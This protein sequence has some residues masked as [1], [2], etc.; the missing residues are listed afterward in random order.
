MARLVLPFADVGSGIKPSS[1][2]KLFF[3]ETGTSTPKDTFSDSAATTPNANPVISDSTGVFADIFIVGTQKVVLKDKN[4][5]QIWEA[6]PVNEFVTGSGQADNVLNRATLNAAVIDTS[7]QDGLAINMAE[8]TVGAD[9]SG[10]MWDVVLASTV[11]PNTFNIVICTGVPTLA[12]VLRVENNTFDIMQFGFLP[13]WNGSTGTDNILTLRAIFEFIDATSYSTTCTGKGTA[14]VNWTTIGTDNSES[15]NVL[16]TFDDIHN[17]DFNFGGVTF[18]QDTPQNDGRMFMRL[19]NSSF[20]TISEQNHIGTL[21][22]D[23]PANHRLSNVQIVNFRE[24]C[25]NI[26]LRN[27]QCNNMYRVVTFGATTASGVDSADR[28]STRTNTIHLENVVMIDGKYGLHCNNA[29][30]NLTGAITSRNLVRTH[31]I[32]N[33]RNHDLIIDSNFGRDKSDILITNQIDDNFPAEEN[34]IDNIKINYITSGKKDGSGG[35]GLYEGFV[36]FTFIQINDNSTIPG[37]ITNVEINLEV[38]NKPVDF[39]TNIVSL[40]KYYSVL[41]VIEPD[42]TT[43]SEHRFKNIKITG[44]V[45]GGAN[46]TQSIIALPQEKHNVLII[47]W[48]ACHFANIE[49]SNF[50]CNGE[51]PEHGIRIDGSS[52]A[53]VDTP[54]FTANNVVLGGVLTVANETGGLINI[55]NTLTKDEVWYD[56]YIIGSNANGEFKKYSDGLLEMTFTGVSTSISSASGSLFATAT[57]PLTFPFPATSI[58]SITASAKKDVG[59]AWATIDSNTLTSCFVRLIASVVGSSALPQYTVIGRWK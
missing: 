18:F 2:A 19:D 5:V 55:S 38:N 28:Y 1:G 57:G 17:V 47:D 7:L 56:G 10:G 9:G 14:Y 24:N 6:D 48:S 27:V 39:T 25:N 13:D 16:H 59:I 50:N 34:V 12:L 20:I 22:V 36:N 8:R 51:S 49:V 54:L 52:A 33:S 40:L 4:D 45:D 26:K 32:Q 31:Y 35:S 11:T 58:D 30:D 44:K 15:T 37:M 46:C 23:T 53:S 41:G 21:L 29:G 3:F 43:D 42:P